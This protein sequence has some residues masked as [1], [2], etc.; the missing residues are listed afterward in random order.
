MPADFWSLLEQS[1]PAA[2]MRGSVWLY[3]LINVVH[4][5]ALLVFFAAVA[6]MDARLLGSLRQMPVAGVLRPCRRIAAAAFVVQATS[7]VLLFSADATAIAG[8]SAFF[9]KMLVI[10]L[11]LANVAVVEGVWGRVLA[12]LPADAPVPAGARLCAGLSLAGWTAAAALGRLIA[13]A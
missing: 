13:Y 12:A 7:G 5:L 3:P 11:A 10:A 1:A 6:A 9:A 4:V 2:A 8:N